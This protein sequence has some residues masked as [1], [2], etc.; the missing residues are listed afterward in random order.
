MLLWMTLTLRILM[1]LLKETVTEARDT[2]GVMKG[3]MMAMQIVEE[4]QARIEH[5]GKVLGAVLEVV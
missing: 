2:I 5:S 3:G 4:K 1:L